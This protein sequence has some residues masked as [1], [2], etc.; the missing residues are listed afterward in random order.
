M[1]NIRKLM[2]SEKDSIQKNRIAIE[3]YQKL[4]QDYIN[5]YQEKLDSQYEIMRRIKE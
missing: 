5:Q 2:D 3:E 1:G 4:A